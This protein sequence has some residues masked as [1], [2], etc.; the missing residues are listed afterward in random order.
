METR[1]PFALKD[2]PFYYSYVYYGFIYN[3]DTTISKHRKLTNQQTILN[4]YII[5]SLHMV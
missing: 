1:Q 5:Q 2:S 3:A 4:I